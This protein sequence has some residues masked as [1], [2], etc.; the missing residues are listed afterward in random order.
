MSITRHQAQMENGW[1]RA[2]ESGG[3]AGSHELKASK[4]WEGLVSIIL[5]GL[6]GGVCGQ[7]TPV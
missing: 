6:P 7:N 1:G 5:K 4:F 2:F 3:P